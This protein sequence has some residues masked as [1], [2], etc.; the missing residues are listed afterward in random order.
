MKITKVL[1][2]KELTILEEINESDMQSACIWKLSYT[3]KMLRFAVAAW[4]FY[5]YSGKR[6][7]KRKTF[8]GARPFITCEQ[9]TWLVQNQERW[10]I[11]LS[12]VKDWGK[13][14]NRWVRI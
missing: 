13:I 9:K 12:Y 4:K 3:N 7:Q 1:N 6:K 11:S 5:Y 8:R 14:S 10:G 2:L